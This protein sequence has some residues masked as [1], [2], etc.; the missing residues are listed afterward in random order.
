M[1]SAHVQAL[2]GLS[3]LAAELER[4]TAALDDVEDVARAAISW[5][6]VGTKILLRERLAAALAGGARAAQGG[7]CVCGKEIIKTVDHWYPA[8]ADDCPVHG[9]RAAQED[10]ACTCHT[11]ARSGTCAHVRALQ[12]EK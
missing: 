8:I 5:A 6:P 10:A 11:F 12:E 7:M 9:A 2:E 1:A 4:V 3:A